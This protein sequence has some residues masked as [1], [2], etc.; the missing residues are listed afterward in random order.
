LVSLTLSEQDPTEI[1]AL[2]DQLDSLTRDAFVV[3]KGELDSAL[4]LHY[5]VSPGELRPWHYQNRFFQEAPAIYDVDLSAFYHDKDPVELAR[6]YYAGIG[7][8]ADSIIAHSDLYEKPGKYQH[9]QSIDV[10]RA[11]DVRILCSVRPDY[12]WM[13]TM[14][15]ELGHG[16]YDY[17]NDRRQPWLLRGAAHSV[18]TEAVA[19]FFGRLSG[20]PGWLERVVGVPKADAEQAAPVC[21]QMQRT[22]QLVFSRWAQVMVRFERALY[23][24]PDQNLNKLWW[25]LVEKYQLLKKPEGRNEP[26]WASKIHLAT[27]PVYYHNY[28]LGELLASQFAYTI[29]TKVLGSSDPFACDFALDPRVGQY[30]RD[31]VFTP[32]AVY[33][34]NDM[35]ERATGEKLTAEYYARQFVGAR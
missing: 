12:Y 7:I 1:A 3:L 16:V 4:S 26:D 5:H 34:W 2:F 22:E 19:L 15:H 11:G 6:V 20:N 21:R 14:L 23:E 29:G 10:D 30:F 27:S 8:P 25:E 17:Y 24:N 32:G 31:K 33:F 13:N 35:I 9:A 28:L 18:T